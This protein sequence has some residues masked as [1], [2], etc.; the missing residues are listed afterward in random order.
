MNR[1]DSVL[2]VTVG[3]NHVD[4]DTAVSTHAE[5]DAFEKL[6]KG[7]Y[8]LNKVKKSL[9]ILVTRITRTGRFVESRPCYHCIKMMLNSD[10]KIKYVYYSS[11]DGT[12]RRE[13]LNKMLENPKT[14]I[15][16]GNRRKMAELKLEL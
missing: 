2:Y 15:S 11:Y 3:Q 12:I 14:Y 6:K 8:K 4:D 9:N 13:R 16:S 5:L 10:I 1:K 7:K